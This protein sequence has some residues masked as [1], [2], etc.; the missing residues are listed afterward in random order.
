MR[1]SSPGRMAVAG[2]AVVLLLVV[3]LTDWLST[4][5]SGFWSSHAMLTNL[6]SSG[7]FAFLTVA[8]IDWWLK[9]QQERQSEQRQ[10]EER[11]RLMIVRS[12]AYN[13]VARGP[14][15][16]RRIMWFLVCGGELRFV[17]EFRL[18]DHHLQE[19]GEILTRLDLPETSEHI[20]MDGRADR[21][22]MSAR[23]ALLAQD[24]QWRTLVHD[25]LLDVVHQFRVLVARWS[26]LLLATDESC[27]ALKDLA[28]QAEELSAV[29]VAS[30]GRRPASDYIGERLEKYRELWN[31]AF[32]NA[33]AME[34]TF[35]DLGGE[36]RT[37]DDPRFTTPG[38][39]LL[40]P[41]DL[42]ALEARDGLPMPS[43]WRLYE[44]Q[45]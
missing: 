37:G 8:V 39:R 4:T 29:F 3:L 44:R 41:A 23:F 15:A 6:V 2:F 24:Q 19:L 38:R 42:A 16:Q 7:V 36:R 5:V 14:I 27:Q 9:K 30:D 10:H 26:A 35:I 22:G 31:R 11:R 33:V 18:A 25:V 21:P 13:A 28:A 17:P 12:V 1:R 20:V 40:P 34:E 45:T 43:T 32:A